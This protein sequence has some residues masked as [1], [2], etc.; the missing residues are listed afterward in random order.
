ML[1]QIEK[2]NVDLDQIDNHFKNVYSVYVQDIIFL[3]NLEHWEMMLT[4]D[5]YN[6]NGFIITNS[7]L[8]TYGCVKTY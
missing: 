6:V 8:I 4:I 5:R 3:L 7:V 2:I 1:N